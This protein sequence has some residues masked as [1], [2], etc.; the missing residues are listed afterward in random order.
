VYNNRA[1]NRVIQ[2]SAAEAARHFPGLWD[3]VRV[4]DEVVIEHDARP[5]AVVPPVAPAPSLDKA[6]AAIAQ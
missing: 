2:I 1:G 5:A 3:H 4:G 6:F